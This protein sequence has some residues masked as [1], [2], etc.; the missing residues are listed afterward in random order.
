MISLF[1]W[2]VFFLFVVIIV[3]PRSHSFNFWHPFFPIHYSL[4]FFTTSTPLVSFLVCSVISF[5]VFYFPCM[6]FSVLSFTLPPPFFF[7]LLLPLFLLVFLSSLSF[8]STFPSNSPFP[9]SSFHLTLLL[10][11]FFCSALSTSFSFSPSFL[12]VLLVAFSLFSFLFLQLF[13]PFSFLPLPK[14]FYF[15]PLP[16]SCLPPPLLLPLYFLLLLSLFFLFTSSSYS[17]PLEC[18]WKIVFKSYLADLSCFLLLI[19]SPVCLDNSTI[20]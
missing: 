4:I 9:S 16:L 8:L 17:N 11:P 15:P 10:N 3:I 6:F 5:S 7:S 13:L 14:H 20:S 18:R 2:R 19:S 1:T 12:H